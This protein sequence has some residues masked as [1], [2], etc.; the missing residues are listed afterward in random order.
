MSIAGNCH[1]GKAAFRADIEI[2]AELKRCTCSFCATRGALLAYCEP[3]RFHPIMQP[4]DDAVYR[5]QARQIEH[6]F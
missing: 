3:Q 5:L 6:H 1:C 2:P 4:T